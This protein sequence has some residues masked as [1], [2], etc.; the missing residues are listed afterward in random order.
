MP[1]SIFNGANTV[2]I[3]KDN[4]NVNDVYSQLTGTNDP[5]SV[6]TAG[7]IGSLY[8]R[9]STGQAYL[10]LDNGSTTNWLEV[11]HGPTTGASANSSAIGIATRNDTWI[12]FSE[13]NKMTLTA[14]WWAIAGRCDLDANADVL[15]KLSVRWGSADGDDTT[16]QPAALTASANIDTAFGQPEHFYQFGSSSVFGLDRDQFLPAPTNYIKLS[17]SDDV[18]LNVRPAMTSASASDVNMRLWAIRLTAN[19]G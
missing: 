19:V 13:T 17:G 15:E 8:I 2:K 18:Y 1:A 14:G 16:T 11:G 10:K 5:T 4:V 3:L 7:N 6:A 12:D 9:N